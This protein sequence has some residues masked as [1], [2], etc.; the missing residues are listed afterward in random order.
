MKPTEFWSPRRCFREPIQLIRD[1]AEILSEAVVAH[2]AADARRAASLIREADLAA[3]GEWTASIWGKGNSQIVR[4]RTVPNAPP[5]LP[6]HKRAKPA[7]PPANMK[8]QLLERDGF[9]CRFCGIPVIDP[10]VRKKIRRAYPQALRWGNENKNDEQHW[11]F[12]CMWLQLDHLVPLSRGGET[13]LEN[14]VVTC[15][16]CN[17]GRVG[18]GVAWTIEEV[19][20]IDPR[21]VP[22][23]KSEWD[24]LIRFR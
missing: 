22:F 10:V 16:P 18:L 5:N 13:S 20:L 3:I 23:V 12:Q 24:G 17:Y 2:L 15:G 4:Y 19:G 8:R 6:S 1:A 11:A 7:Y 14:L 21:T 9:N